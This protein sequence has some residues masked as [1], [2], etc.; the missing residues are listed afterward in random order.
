MRN[1]S[2]DDS[3]LPS[4]AEGETSETVKGTLPLA[5]ERVE[6]AKQRVVQGRVTVSRRTTEREQTIEEWL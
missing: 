5:Q 3:P 1:H 4:A 2:A 6:V